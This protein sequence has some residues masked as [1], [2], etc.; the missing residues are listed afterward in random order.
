MAQTDH[1]VYGDAGL[2]TVSSVVASLPVGYTLGEERQQ[3]GVHYRLMYNAGGEQIDQG[4]IASPIAS[5]GGPYSATVTT[6]TDTANAYGAVVA[7]NA[8]A[9]TGTYFWG[10]FRGYP[11]PLKGDSASHATG[12]SIMVGVDGGVATFV[13]F[14]TA[15]A[16]G[17]R[18]PNAVIGVV[19]GATATGTIT[20]DTRSGDVLIDFPRYGEAAR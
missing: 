8:T 17:Q 19:I 6:V 20:T 1:R 13:T 2:G 16:A 18:N 10:A 3:D 14:A 15:G 11:I 12:T 5:G 9:T 4:E 7:H